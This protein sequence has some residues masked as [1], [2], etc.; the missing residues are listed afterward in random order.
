MRNW[1]QWNST[2]RLIRLASDLRTS[3]NAVLL[4]LSALLGFATGL[5]IWVFQEAIAL[6]HD[7]FSGL[8]ETFSPAIGVLTVVIS[9]AAA[10]ALVGWIM[11]RFIGEERHHGVAGIME[12]VALAGGRLRYRRMPYKALAS[13]LSLGAGASVGPEDP[14]V[15]IGANMGSWFAHALHV[16]EDQARL[17]VAAGA[18]SAISAAFGAPIAGVFFA[19]EVILNGAFETRS[20]GVIVLASVIASAFTQA[21]RP[22][23]EMGPFNYALGTPL[24]IPLFIPLGL[25][26]ALV[27]VLF[28]RAIYW[29]HDLWH[30]FAHLPRAARTALAGGLVGG[31]GIFLPQIMGTGRET[32]NAVLNGDLEL[33][34]LML[35]AL[36]GFKLLM[37]A[38]S[39]AG[40]FVGGIFAPSLFVG[41]MVGSFYGHVIVS[42]FRDPRLGDPQAYAIVGMAASMAG[43]VR[44]PITAIMMVFELTNDYRL[45]LPIMLATVICVYVAEQFERHGIYT[46][47]LL[48]KGVHLPQGRETDLMQGV[49]VEEAML[50][51]APTISASASLTELRDTLRH[52]HSNS[53]CVVDEEGLL[54]GVVTLSDLQRAYAAGPNAALTVDEICSRNVVT[55]HAQQQ[56]W[57]AIRLMS[58][59]D[60]GRVPVV[61]R[62]TREV[63]G[64][65]GRHGVVRAYNVAIAR[66]LED[67]HLAEQIRLNTLTGGHVAEY[68]VEDDSPLVEHKIRD[69]QWPS[70]SAIVAIRRHTRLL[71]PHGDTIFRVSDVVTVIYEGDAED[72]FRVLFTGKN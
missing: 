30:R 32:M 27:S 17:L 24:E 61:R 18:A 15:Q 33:S 63:I 37:T 1:K 43:V 49:T 8:Q 25:V 16:T 70:E 39:M 34:L 10:G 65:I 20:F 50:K 51:P 47:S 59:H 14:S 41:T 7:L 35:L 36:S 55:V 66:K 42:I 3:E 48:R 4:A 29:Q 57:E 2:G 9:L 40:G 12:A 23:A 72:S 52:Y 53:L 54:C 26:L 11:E 13:A 68:V 64:L 46:Q 5:G 6:I 58:L 45:I 21:L 19:L 28:V 44:S 67:Q 60:I 22:A 71:V 31:V 62:G 69:I 38:I 56:V